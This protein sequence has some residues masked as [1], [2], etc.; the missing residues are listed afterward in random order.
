MPFDATEILDVLE[1][2]NTAG[3]KYA[4]ILRD[5]RDW[6]NAWLQRNYRIAVETDGQEYAKHLIG[7]TLA[8]VRAL[9]KHK[10]AS[11]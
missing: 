6:A 10:R 8:N 4:L 9:P 11:R 1:T 2:K 5:G 7:K 3:T